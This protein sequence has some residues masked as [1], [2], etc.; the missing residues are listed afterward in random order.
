MLSII[1]LAGGHGTRFGGELPKQFL[2]LNGKSILSYSIDFFQSLDIEKEIILV[3]AKEYRSR[4]PGNF[5][6]AEPGKRRQDSTYNG[7]QHA[8]FPFTCVHDGVRPNIDPQNFKKL[9]NEAKKHGAAALASPVKNTIKEAHDG[10]VVRTLDRQ[11]LFEAHTP[12]I[13]RTDLL[14]KGFAAAKNITVTDDIALMELINHPSKLVPDTPNNI[15]ITTPSDL[16]LLKNLL[17]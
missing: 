6:F 14:K 12:Q 16:E 17:Q 4:L 10:F 11:N 2:E 5:I 3:C 9:L 7:L 1:I 13:I 8:S 15:K